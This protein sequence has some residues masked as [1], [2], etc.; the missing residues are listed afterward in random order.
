MFPPCSIVGK[1]R[2]AEQRQRLAP[3]VNPGSYRF[4]TNPAAN[5]AIQKHPFRNAQ[6]FHNHTPHTADLHSR[7]AAFAP[8][9]STAGSN[10]GSYR[11]RTN[12][13]ANAAIQKHPFRNAQP[14][15][16]D[17][18]HTADLHS[19]NAALPPHRLDRGLRHG[20]APVPRQPSRKCGEYAAPV[21]EPN[22]SP[23]KRRPTPRQPAVVA[24][25]AAN[26]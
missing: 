8:T 19:R 3:G 2:A 26:R 7:N 18:P 10:P 17:T 5:A 20:V 6:P 14:F 11:F 1:V 24:A 23:K 13:A 4:C 15:H 25:Y 9:G 12:P 21:R 16:N 22:A